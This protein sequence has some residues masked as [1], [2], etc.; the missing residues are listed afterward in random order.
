MYEVMALR[1]K[2]KLP[3][4]DTEVG[5]GNEFV[6]TLSTNEMVLVDK[7]DFKTSQIDWGNPDY[8]ELSNYLYRVQKITDGE[9]TLRHHL[10]SVLKDKDGKEIGRI[11]KSPN[12]FQ[13]IKVKINHIGQISRA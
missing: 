3:V 6:M 1:K 12:S 7:D 5:E 11:I 4:I 13:G 10:T 2:N 8:N 9:I